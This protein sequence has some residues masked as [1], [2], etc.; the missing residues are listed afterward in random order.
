MEMISNG[1][2]EW[3]GTVDQPLQADATMGAYG[4]H[5]RRAVWARR[6]TR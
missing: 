6:A 2:A 3:S 5:A 4:E 1:R